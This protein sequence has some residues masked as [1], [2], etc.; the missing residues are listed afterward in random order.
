[1]KTKKHFWISIYILFLTCFTQQIFSQPY[2]YYHGPEKEI[3]GPVIT[4]ELWRFNL[5]TNTKELFFSDSVYY[6]AAIVSWDPTQQW[7]FLTQDNSYSHMNPDDYSMLTGVVNASNRRIVHV[8][9]DQYPHPP[10]TYP[11]SFDDHF[12]DDKIV[13]DGIVY[14]PIKNVFYVTWFLPRPDTVASYL[15]YLAYERTA[16]YDATTLTVVDTLA[17]PPDWITAQASVSDDGNYLY[18]VNY[19]SSYP[20]AIG[21]YSLAT[22]QLIINRNLSD[23]VVP[24]IR[25]GFADSKKGKYLIGYR[26]P[27]SQSSDGK[28][29]LY[30]IDLDTSVIIPFQE[31]SDVS[32]S[33]DGKYVIIEETPLK[34]NYLELRVEPHELYDHPGRISVFNG[35]TGQLIQK[36]KLPPDGKVLVFDNYPNMLYYYVEKKQKSIN[37]DLNKLVIIG[38]MSPQIVLVGSGAFTLSISGKNFTPESKVCLNGTNR[39]TTFIADTLLQ[40]TIRA[41]DADAAMTAYIAVKDTLAQSATATTDSLA[42]NIVS[43]PSQSLVPLVNCITQQD[44]T[45]YTAWFGYENDSAGSIT[46]PIGPQNKFT[47]T[48]N[49]RTQPTVFEP[50]RKDKIFSVVFNSKSLIWKLNGNEVT[51]SK[52]SPKCN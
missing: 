28:Y 12:V 40:A 9:P 49:D 2:Y 36:L 1:M 8:F 30:N 33:S 18:L 35:V 7:I 19:E 10:G 15:G 38:A 37:I 32:I 47:P 29:A 25:K 48:P 3:S 39:A 43:I 42:L 6:G 4:P 5:Q 13:Y 51:A 52:K 26:Y 21:K 41:A 23:I 24:G 27:T 11:N 44:D 22:K 50:G 31:E 20:V 14:N 45:T 17:V 16:V 46:V 34:P